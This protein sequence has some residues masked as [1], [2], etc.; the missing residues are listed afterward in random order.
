V[1][2]DPL[3]LAVSAIQPGVQYVASSS[4]P[5]TTE[6]LPPNV[7]L[8]TTRWLN[9]TT[10]LVR[11]SHMF[12]AGEHA[13]MSK[14]ATVQLA[15]VAK[16][17][18]LKVT[19]VQEATLF[20]ERALND[21]DERRPQYNISE[22]LT[23]WQPPLLLPPTTLSF[24]SSRMVGSI[25]L[26]TG[27]TLNPMQIRAF[28]FEVSRSTVCSDPPPKTLSIAEVLPAGAAV[29]TDNSKTV[30]LLVRQLPSIDPTVAQVASLSYS[31]LLLL[32][33]VPAGIAVG[34]ASCLVARSYM[35]K[36][37]AAG[38]KHDKWK[39]I[40]RNDCINL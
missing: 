8:L 3:Q 6:G 21:S 22:T 10:I 36:S 33:L 26:S 29:K 31:V 35:L 18:K 16:L 30:S 39:R 40:A 38:S 32:L 23:K 15:A 25:P 5:T 12:Q 24:T 14:P 17:L 37:G 27:V 2:N 1:L 13:R 4:K 19:R 7:H 11:L 34:I 20:G 28:Y 9:C